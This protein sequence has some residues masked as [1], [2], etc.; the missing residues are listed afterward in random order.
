VLCERSLK[1]LD[2]AYHGIA[3]PQKTCAGGLIEKNIA[4]AR[5][6]RID[7]TPAIVFPNGK[8][9]MGALHEKD[10]LEL[11]EKNLR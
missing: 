8:I 10:F 9:N 6:Y 3:L 7:G 4:L 2:D 5:K 1:L 11:L